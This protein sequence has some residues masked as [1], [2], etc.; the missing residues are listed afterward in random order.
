MGRDVP[1]DMNATCDECG[2]PGAYDFMGDL[3][4][5]NCF[6]RMQAEY[7]RDDDRDKEAAEAEATKELEPRE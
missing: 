4:C 5:G 2:N 6:S 1:F 7:K 3:I